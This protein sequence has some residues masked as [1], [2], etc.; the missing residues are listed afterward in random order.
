M[1]LKHRAGRA[2]RAMGGAAIGATALAI[3]FALFG[4]HA[5]VGQVRLAP[6]QAD[7]EQMPNSGVYLPND[8]ALS[9]AMARARERLDAAEYQQA[10]TFLQQTLTREEDSFLDE[11]PDGTARLGLK[12]SARQM[13]GQ[14]P[15]AGREA[16][17]LL[18]GA[19]ARRQLDA[20][21]S[22]GDRS[23][24]AQ[25]VRQFFHTT[26]GY[27]AALVLAQMESDAGRH[28]AAAQLYQELL[29][30]PRA[31][32]QLDP[33]LSLLAAVN[34]LSA[35]RSTESTATLKALIER[36]PSA[37]VELGGRKVPLPGAQSDLA[38]WLAERAGTPERIA[39]F[40]RDWST[41]HGN[42]ARNAQH[43]GGGP[44]LRTR[45]QARVVNDPNI[46]EFLNGR[47][48][49]FAERGIVVIPA[50]RPIAV[51]DVV[52]MRTPGNVVAVDWQTG[53]RVWET[54][55][56][57][58]FAND[59]LL[60][61]LSTT[62]DGPDA[63]AAPANILEQR[64]W[65][66]AL[67]MSL[68]SDGERAYVI[69]GA[70]SASDETD[71]DIRLRMLGGMPNANLPTTNQLAAFDLATEGK[72]V[73]EQDGA[74]GAGP[75]A[76]AFF[77]GPPLAVDNT[78]YVLAEIRNA[79]YLLAID[80]KTGRHQ[81]Q[82]QLVGLE[83]GI[84]LD[85][86]RRMAGSMP[87]YSGGT[88][89]CPTAAGATIAV[90]VVRRELAWVYEY[91]RDALSRAELQLMLQQQTQNQAARGNNQ[92][93]DSSAIINEGRVFLTPPESQELHCV[94]LRSGTGL[95]K[96]R[97]EDAR[98]VGCVDQGIVLLVGGRTVEALRASDGTAAWQDRTIQ[99]PDGTRPAGQGYL[100][101]GR[102][103]LPLSSGAVLTID[104][105]G[106]TQVAL[107]AGESGTRLG[108][109]ICVR[110]SVISQSPLVM[111]KFEQLDVL[112]KRAEAAL[113]ANAN[114]ARAM[115]ELAE[116]K[117]VAGKAPEA[118]G[119]L[120]RAHTLTPNDPLIREMLAEYLLAALA[121]DYGTARGELPLLRSLI[122]GKNQE[123]KLLRI[124]ARGLE[125]VGERLAAWDAYLRV[126]DAE[127][128]QWTDLE[129]DVDHTVRSDR[130]L[131]GRVTSLWTAASSDEQAA[132]S[133]RVEA[134]AA[135]LGLQPDSDALQKF[136]VRFGGLP[137]AEPVRMKL[138]SRL[139]ANQQSEAAEIE[140]LQLLN[141]STAEIQAGAAALIA[142]SLIDGGRPD[143]AV[144]YGKALLSKWRSTPT[145]EGLT[146]Q[147]WVE[148]LAAESPAFAAQLS[149][150]W[151]RGRVT[152]RVEASPGP[153]IAA[154]S[155]FAPV[156]QASFRQLRIEQE[157]QIANSADQ[158]FISIDTAQ[159]TQL[160]G[161][162]NDG[163]DF[164]SLN[165][166]RYGRRR[167]DHT[168][169]H[170]ARLGSLLFVAHGSRIAAIDTRQVA[171]SGQVLWEA[172][173]LGP[174][175]T[176]T[177]Q[178]ARG[179]AR[180]RALVFDNRSIRRR[181]E[182]RITSTALGPVTP[183]GVVFYDQTELKCV[184]PLSGDTL[185]SRRD[186]P[187]NCELFGD[188]EWLFAVKAAERVAHVIKIADGD[189]VD[190]RP[191]A[192]LST[193]LSAQLS[194]LITSGRNVAH[195]A[196]PG[197]GTDPLPLTV[198]DL[199]S[200]DT[201]FHAKFHGESRL[202][203]VEPNFVAVYEPTGKFQ[204][205]DVR[206]GKL[207]IDEQLEA[208]P[209]AQNIQVDISGDDLILAISSN[210]PAGRH[211]TVGMAVDYPL[212]SGLIYAFD[213][214]SGKPAW[215]APAAV[216]ERGLVLA[217]PHDLPF[218]V[219]ADR[220]ARRETAM[221]LRLL[222][223][224]K[225]TGQS[226]YRNDD[227]LDVTDGKFR[228]RKIANPADAAA[229]RDRVVTIE[230]SAQNIRLT[231][232]DQPRPPEPPARDELAADREIGERGIRGALLRATDALQL[233]QQQSEANR[234]GR[235]VRR[236]NQ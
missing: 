40:E 98:F 206:T 227:L 29:D 81:W 226:V 185:W 189:L 209:K 177:T 61:M 191:I 168:I 117:R 37:A 197:A 217:G 166:E 175:A 126:A 22:G 31:V 89:V 196:P 26:A 36:N 200:G 58:G 113:A 83:Q 18:Y 42:A 128:G 204:L 35:G 114:D 32:A 71:M 74:R 12:A 180:E 145:V 65:D 136:L 141:S 129:I 59:Q 146:G 155:P 43:A 176:G 205:V 150:S 124:E 140:L 134:F 130:W 17:E 49:Q 68:S 131:G 165:F 84:S 186:L 52:L 72:L 174:P 162:K 170:G 219:F 163:T 198:V 147:Q 69:R 179:R 108:N 157:Q 139:V 192:Q 28:L 193:Q 15:A 19:A 76:G 234:R 223:L 138:A 214:K 188:S 67:S 222:C 195:T 187:R 225:R 153:T 184:D 221:K 230:T 48:R 218:V 91:S 16:F 156:G 199:L 39:N 164:V 5:I 135:A 194:W 2:S 47:S 54:R 66:D 3:L 220:E 144:D 24:V 13:I 38:N 75:L 122:S 142:K 79:I 216:E 96:R 208:Y 103:H 92:W 63:S 57:E 232:T 181:D 23:G 11:S 100:S 20:A 56:E 90:D 149:E 10:L 50:A 151:P 119:L 14:L 64:L 105:A 99:I 137:A 215:P 111:D 120:K 60:P 160:V 118:I 133:S 143:A 106:G 210:V 101:E 109:L 178:N 132:M 172:D 95:W 190:R 9:R 88:L 228:I 182:N 82:Q 213:L 87:S 161:R 127:A 231:L 183:R 55:V 224:D 45:W 110:G 167:V 152:A 53:K 171:S 212:V 236:G 158:W 46:E 201:L 159:T 107:T 169:S 8:R 116:L 148:R 21:V 80:P 27:E 73:W 229:G 97:Q 62:E 25:V 235:G 51:G 173:A 33:Q 123:L 85:T 6:W 115:R 94:D 41:L 211:Q 77:L 86:R 4:G 70:N 202:A 207:L 30:S 1:D 203:V 125:K 104:V 121:D 34:H 233:Q 112:Q 154:A 102:Y 78:L 93:L 7:N 44:H